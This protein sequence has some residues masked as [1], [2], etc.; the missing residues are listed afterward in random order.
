MVVLQHYSSNML[1]KPKRE[2]FMVASYRLQYKGAFLAVLGLFLTTI[3]MG[4][5]GLVSIGW[6]ILLGVGAVAVIAGGIIRYILLESPLF[7]EILKKREVVRAPVAELFRKQWKTVVRLIFTFPYHVTAFFLAIFP[8]GLS[9][10]IALGI[11]GIVAYSS[12]LI[13]TVVGI[14]GCI[15][16]GY[17]AE[18]IGRKY[19][20]MISAILTGIFVYTYYLLVPTKV[21]ALVAL[22]IALLNFSINFGNGVIAAFF[23]EHFPTKYRYSGVGV[24]YQLSAVVT[25]VHSSVFLPLAIVAAGGIVKAP[26]YMIIMILSLVIIAIIALSLLKE[27]KKIDLTALDMESVAKEQKLRE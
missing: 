12:L 16:G 11:P 23:S 3:F 26:F 8:T 24:S 7:Q 5:A 13:G 18:I 14:I 15:V 17:L 2:H 1:P 20:L 27:T 4:Q 10:M 25:G 9:Y 22:A 6:R 19:V 21:F